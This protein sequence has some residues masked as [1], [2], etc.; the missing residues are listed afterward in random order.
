MAERRK[1]TFIAKKPTTKPVKVEFHTKE[2][3]VAFGA[4]KKISKPVKVTFYVVEKKGK[5]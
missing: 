3:L 5:K 2:G 1:V 4:K